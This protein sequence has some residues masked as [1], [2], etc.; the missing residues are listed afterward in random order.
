MPDV[1]EWSGC[2]NNEILIEA[3]QYYINALMVWLSEIDRPMQ[4]R[5]VLW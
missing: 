2:P 3:I 1:T 5:A 4:N